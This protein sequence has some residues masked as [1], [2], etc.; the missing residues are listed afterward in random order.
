MV[1]LLK[2]IK[3]NIVEEGPAIT[4]PAPD[5]EHMKEV[6]KKDKFM[7]KVYQN[8]LGED[9]ESFENGIAI[10]E[11]RHSPT[12]PMSPFTSSPWPAKKGEE[13]V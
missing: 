6:A 11:I 5:L 12:A 10:G 8:E 13:D 3:E 7:K 2:L 4:Y 9:F 1:H